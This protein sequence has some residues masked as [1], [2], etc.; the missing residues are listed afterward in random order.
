MSAAVKINLSPLTPQQFLALAVEL[1]QQLE[2]QLHHTS[3]LGLLAYSGKQGPAWKTD[4]SIRISE[5]EAEI[6]SYSLDPKNKDPELEQLNIDRFL[7]LF[8]AIKDQ[9]Q[10]EALDQKY[11]ALQSQLTPE[12]KDTVFGT[13]EDP[14]S[15]QQPHK[16]ERTGFAFLF[17][18][19]RGYFITPLLIYLNIAVFIAMV[20]SGVNAFLP[21]TQSLIN[22]GA[23]LRPLVLEGAWWRLI[24]C[25]FVHMG[26]VH[27]SLNMYAL[28]YI[29]VLL[30]PH[31]GKL[32]FALAYLLTGV[33][34][35]LASLWWHPYAA[36]VGASGAIFGIYGVFLA[37]LTTDIIEEKRRKPLLISIGIF[38]VYNLVFGLSGVVD[39]AAHIG[40]L[41]SGVIIGFAWL[42]GIRE[43]ENM[44]RTT[45][46]IAI[47]SLLIISACAATI[48]GMPDD[49]ATYHKK[50]AEFAAH[51]KT[52]LSIN[53]NLTSDDSK[54][55]WL[56]VIRDSGLHN[57]DQCETIL[58]QV[59]NLD[60]PKNVRDHADKLL[61]YCDWQIASYSYR[62]RQT[63]A[64]IGMEMDSMTYYNTQ[65]QSILSDLQQP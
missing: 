10:T 53:N 1:I 45:I 28:L 16:K 54:E 46:P 5:T 40:G 35:S 3:N 30:E 32:R 58:N 33:I 2:W 56:S 57:W 48:K 64:G 8:E 12:E 50:M 34:A 63:Q 19:T 51:E 6:T 13:A 22:W 11:A 25:M 38:V 37:L 49:L 62:Y 61:E 14:A 47:T 59:K 7:H 41:L 4:V 27:I 20:A 52:A 60:L 31:L 23:N 42:P 29:G 15:T 17:A 21:D 24:T 65:I 26:I 43:P 39:N 9:Y 18:P 36:A 44:R 55:K